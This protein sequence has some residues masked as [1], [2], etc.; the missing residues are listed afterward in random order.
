MHR[1]ILRVWV[2]VVVF[3]Y[4]LN[5]YAAVDPSRLG[6][7][8][9]MEW[10]SRAEHDLKIFIYDKPL[11]LQQNNATCYDYFQAEY[12]IPNYIRNVSLYT[13]NPDQANLFLIEHD[14]TCLFTSGFLTYPQLPMHIYRMRFIYNRHLRPILNNVTHNYPYF[15][16]SG[17]KDHIFIMLTDFGPYCQYYDGYFRKAFDLL[18]NVTFLLNFGHIGP[19]PDGSQCMRPPGTDIILPQYHPWK[20]HQL[21][22]HSELPREIDSFFVG[23]YSNRYFCSVNIRTILQ[24]IGH[25]MTYYRL[26]N[27]ESRSTDGKPAIADSYFALCPAGY[28]PWSKRLYEALMMNTI[29][30]ILANGIVEP[31]EKFLNWEDFTVKF[32]TDNISLT[33]LSFLEKIHNAG[34][35]HRE[36]NRRNRSH[37][38]TTTTTTLPTNV[39]EPVARSRNHHSH[40]HNNNISKDHQHQ[41]QR[42]VLPYIQRK[43]Q[44]VREAAN[45]FHWDKD[46]THHRSV[47]K[48]LVLEL[49][50]KT[51]TGLAETICQRSASRIANQEYW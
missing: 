10:I 2:I 21:S 25:N 9:L 8:L 43:L 47:W 1:P 15:N 40:H 48:L 5:L 31:F 13:T 37:Q 39:A 28:A 36:W 22:L 34:E 46:V 7:Q 17:G 6:D 27:S 26:F 41:H 50:C 49:W 51:P 33:N 4:C 42:Y 18:R 35:E 14:F 11:S 30:V 29:P 16:R 20:P 3:S 45:W 32:N 44:M 12:R 38:T 23:L 24:S 19:A